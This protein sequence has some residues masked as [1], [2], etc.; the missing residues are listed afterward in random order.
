MIPVVATYYD[1]KRVIPSSLV[2]C[3]VPG[4][5]TSMV[6]DSIQARWT[7]ATYDKNRHT[8]SCFIA[9]ATLEERCFYTKPFAPRAAYAARH[10]RSGRKSTSNYYA[11]RTEVHD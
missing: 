6:L 10:A 7:E 11:K 5:G 3:I 1:D 4:R 2:S 8:H 9:Y